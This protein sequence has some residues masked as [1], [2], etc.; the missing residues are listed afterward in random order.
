MTIKELFQ[1]IGNLASDISIDFSRKVEALAKCSEAEADLSKV[2]SGAFLRVFTQDAKKLS[3]LTGKPYTD[4]LEQARDLITSGRE[5]ADVL[6]YFD[7]VLFKLE[8][9]NQQM[10]SK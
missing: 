2:S 3:E 1:Q 9:G 7:S 5:E 6:F 4:Y 10:T 8:E